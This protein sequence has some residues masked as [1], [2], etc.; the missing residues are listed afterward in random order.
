M[1]TGV[2]GTGRGGDFG[3]FGRL[4]LRLGCAWRRSSLDTSKVDSVPPLNSGFDLGVKLKLM[5][6]STIKI[7]IAIASSNDTRDAAKCHARAKVP[8]DTKPNS[9]GRGSARSGCK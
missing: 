6:A 9:R 5:N 3:R 2:G 7:S 8:G 4:L 1:G